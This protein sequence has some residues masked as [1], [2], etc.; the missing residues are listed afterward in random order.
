LFSGQPQQAAR[1]AEAGRAVAATPERRLL[2]DVGPVAL[3]TPHP[4]PHAQ[5]GSEWVILRQVNAESDEGLS[6]RSAWRRPL[7]LGAVLLFAAQVITAVVPVPPSNSGDLLGWV[8]DHILVLQIG[9]ELKMFASV[10]LL[11]GVIGVVLTRRPVRGFE[12]LSVAAFAMAT[13]LIAVTV[14]V[15]GRLAYPVFGLQLTADTAIL[16]ISLMYGAL[17]AVSVLFAGGI[18]AASLSAIRR[19][20]RPLLPWAGAIAGVAQVF[21]SFPW[22]MPAWV[23]MVA[24]VTLLLW[25]LTAVRLLSNGSMPTT[26]AP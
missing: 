8:A 26:E 15:E 22:L 12:L 2:P 23:N 21:G 17:H 4:P 18:F 14:L 13:V 5:P 3:L 7:M 1:L 24:A 10:F 11:A 20:T 16:V 9:N 25:T 6:G 19:G